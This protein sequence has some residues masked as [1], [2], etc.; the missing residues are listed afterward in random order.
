MAVH[1]GRLREEKEMAR[2]KSTKA[3][4]KAEEIVQPEP[5]LTLDEAELPAAPTADA[6]PEPGKNPDEVRV[7]IKLTSDLYRQYQKEA[8]DHAMPAASLMAYALKEWADANFCDAA[9]ALSAADAVKVA[10]AFRA[11]FGDK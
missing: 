5:E 1:G 6:A 10:A 2:K 8:K 3:P 7:N 11:M 4:K 9:P